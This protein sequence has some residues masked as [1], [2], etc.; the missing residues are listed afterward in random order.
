[1]NKLKRM[2]ISR[3]VY[4]GYTIQELELCLGEDHHKLAGWIQA[5]WLQDHLQGTRRHDGNG[6][7]IH[8]IREKDLLTSLGAIHAK[9]TSAKWIRLDF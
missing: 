4:D 5:G 1:M 9:S 8:R 7:D 6:N 3:R 2:G